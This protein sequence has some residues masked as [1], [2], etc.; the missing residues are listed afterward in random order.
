MLVIAIGGVN[1]EFVNQMHNKEYR[2]MIY[3]IAYCG[4]LYNIYIVS[5]NK[6]Y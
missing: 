6:S 1:C 5:I 4:T 2:V 3:A